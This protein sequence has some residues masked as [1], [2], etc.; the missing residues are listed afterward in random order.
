MSSS[1][2]TSI[3]WVARE[4]PGTAPAGSALYLTLGEI[5][6]AE[7]GSHEWRLPV[8][9]STDG[10][11]T[12]PLRRRLTPEPSC[13][14]RPAPVA[15]EMPLF[16]LMYGPTVYVYSLRITGFKP[17]PLGIPR[18]ADLSLEGSVGPQRI[19]TRPER[20]SRPARSVA[21]FLSAETRSAALPGRIGMD[22]QNTYEDACRAAA[23]DELG[24]GGTYHLA[25]RDL[26]ALLRQHV[27]GYEAVDFGCG[28]GRTARLLQSLG[29]R[30]IGLDVSAEMVARARQ[31]DPHGDYRLIEDGDFSSVAPGSVDLVLSAFPFDNIPGRDRKIRLLRGLRALLRPGGKLINIVSAPELY[32]HEWVTFTNRG[33]DENR[34]ARCGDVVR[35]VITDNSDGRPVEDILWPDEDY[36]TVYREA[37]LEVEWME[38]PLATGDEGVDWVSETRVAPWAIY[39]LRAGVRIDLE[40]RS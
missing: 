9:R 3:G 35:I 33:L 29:F 17:S 7:G 37:G 21:T 23:Y 14:D 27:D 1:K 10:G 24:L 31:R 40:P 6:L 30:V 28:A 11:A 8:F 39:V 5:S 32:T 36:R 13:P 12:F 38:K 22:F 16:P 20:S 2:C 26:P 4:A 34:R 25:F 19:W 18:F 15:E